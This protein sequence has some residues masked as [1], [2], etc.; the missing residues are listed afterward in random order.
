MTHDDEDL[1]HGIR[2]SLDDSVHALD[3]QTQSRLRQA[4]QRALDRL[5]TGHRWR[6]IHTNRFIQTSLALVSVAAIAVMLVWSTPQPSPILI[7]ADDLEMMTDIDGLELYENL[8]FY[9]WLATSSDI[10]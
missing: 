6:T 9:E 1:I 2:T 4:R 3:G 5:D 7:H 8:E 10:G